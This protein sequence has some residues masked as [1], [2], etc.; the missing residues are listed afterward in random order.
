MTSPGHLI[1]MKARSNLYI[2]QGRT[3]LYR[4]FRYICQYRVDVMCTYVDWHNI[5]RTTNVTTFF[6]RKTYYLSLKSFFKMLRLQTCE[7]YH[8]WLMK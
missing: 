7:I 5:H 6:Y 4:L 2:D 8:F 3:T 1:A